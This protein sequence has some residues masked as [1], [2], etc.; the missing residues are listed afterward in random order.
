MGSFLGSIGLT[1]CV[2]SYSAAQSDN[3][4]DTPKNHWAYEAISDLKSGGALAGYPE[5]LGYRPVVASRYE[6]AVKAN[7]AFLRTH[8]IV[9]GMAQ[10]RG[11]IGQLSANTAGLAKRL[12]DWDWGLKAV[13]PG[14]DRHQKEIL[15]LITT[16]STELSKLG[17]DPAEMTIQLKR[18]TATFLAMRRPQPGEAFQQFS[19]VP[20]GHWA[21]EATQNLRSLGIL[22]GYPDGKLRG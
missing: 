17:A 6:F 13:K 18:D 22:H 5:G 11:A 7:A 10:E 20:T 2:S 12:A 1:L 9:S 19:D 16:F 15:D 21:A 4:P 14:F 8:N 3:F